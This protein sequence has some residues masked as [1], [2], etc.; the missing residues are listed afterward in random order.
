MGERVRDILV[1]FS[2]AA[3]S[4]L[5]FL[6]YV[7]LDA[8]VA[9]SFGRVRRLIQRG[10]VETCEREGWS[11][12]FTQLT[13]HQAERTAPDGTGRAMPTP[14]ETQ[15]VDVDLGATASNDATEHRHAAAARATG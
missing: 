3:A 7:T 10:C 6:V 11:I 12:P 5:D 1:E 2:T 8:S 14:W 15:V 9:A 13:V 4:S